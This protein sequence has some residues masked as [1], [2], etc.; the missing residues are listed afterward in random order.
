MDIRFTRHALQ[1]M[2]E[3]DIDADS[4]RAVVSRGESIEDYPNDTPLPSRLVLGWEANRPIHVVVAFSGETAIIVT[5]YE[6]APDEW[7]E[8]FRRR[9]S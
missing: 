2:L 7:D 4:V 6:P 5:C 1:R 3:R 9:K 8:E